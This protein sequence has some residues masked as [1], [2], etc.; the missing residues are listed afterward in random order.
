MTHPWV[1]VGD[2]VY[3]RRYAF[4]DQTIGAV[5][6]RAG[7]LLIDTRSTHGHADELRADLRALT[8]SPVA[9]V[10]NTHHHWDHTFG[11]ARFLPGPIWGHE[12]CAAALRAHG[13]EMRGEVAEH[14]PDLAAHL[15][16]VVITPPDR[17]FAD[18]AEIDLGDRIVALRY[19]GR[20]HTDNDVVA[21]VSDAPVLF[22]GDLLENDAPPSYGD[23]YPTAWAD[24]VGE[25][26]LPLIE[27]TVVPGHGRPGD[28]AFARENA[29]ELRAMAELGRQAAAGAID[30]DA[31]VRAAPY[32]QETA[33]DAIERSRLEFEAARPMDAHA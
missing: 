2:R 29:A 16:E 5:I 11:N 18:R 6:G 15:G 12:R 26:L 10:L 1:E 4:L 23:A 22:A 9:A 30:L 21:L 17:T 31:A 27:G 14:L 28:L 25:R 19:L 8:D 32:P 24:T 33:R 20:G 7:V 3:V 13:D